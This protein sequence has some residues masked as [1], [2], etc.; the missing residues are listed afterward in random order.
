MSDD[1]V[2]PVLAPYRTLEEPG[3]DY[4]CCMAMFPRYRGRGAGRH[5]LRLAEEHA[6]QLGMDKVSLIVFEQNTGAKALY[7][8]EGSVEKMRVP[9]VSHPLIHHDGDALLMV[10]ELGDEYLA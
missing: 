1:A 3:S 4:I 7:E 5:L 9:V 6:R 2:D 10:K 8:R